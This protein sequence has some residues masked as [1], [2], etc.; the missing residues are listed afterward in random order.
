MPAK[1]S[2]PRWG[3]PCKVTKLASAQIAAERISCFCLRLGT[4]RRKPRVSLHSLRGLSFLARAVIAGVGQARHVEFDWVAAFVASRDKET[5][6]GETG[7]GK[8]NTPH[9]LLPDWLA[10]KTAP[11]PRLPRQS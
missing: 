9:Y 11:R 7:Q 10:R 2:A 6:N 3:R 1:A 4:T 8:N 5:P